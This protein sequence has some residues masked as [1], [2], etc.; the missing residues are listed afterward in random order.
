MIKNFHIPRICL[1]PAIGCF[2]ILAG[3]SCEDLLDGLDDDLRDLLV[4]E[5]M[6]TE[7]PAP[8]KSPE[9][10]YWVEITKHPLD[11]TSVL[12]S[13]FYNVGTS[14]Q[15]VAV[16]SGT[17]LTLHSQPLSGGFIVSGS[18]NI[19]PDR[20]TINWTYN[21]DDGSGTPETYSAEYKKKG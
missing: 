9:E 7:N 20:E 19:G 11:S 6:V 17:K 12:I 3:S 21:V 8:L 5:W 15:A 4:D 13:N 10:V 1:L 2:L 14:A 16:L 18:G